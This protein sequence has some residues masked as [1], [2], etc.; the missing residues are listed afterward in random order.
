MPGIRLHLADDVMVVCSAA[1]RELGD[2]DP[3][4]PYWAFAWVGGLALA[5]YLLENP[6]QVAGRSVF[7]LATGSGLCA[8]VAARLG[9]A[10]VRAADIDPLAEAAVAVNAQANELRVA[11]RRMDPLDGPPPDV[12]VLLAGDVCY[13]E[14]MAE[15]MLDWLARAAAN[16]TRVLLG[17]PGRRYLPPGLEQVASYRIRTTREL[18]DAEVKES[19]V[20]SIG[21]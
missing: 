19:A 7:D 1:G 13:E 2:P 20:F 14:T 12:E 11:V 4:L 21:R 9:A 8:L 18:E 10:S 16:G 3:A 17:D 5:R 6:H 15:R